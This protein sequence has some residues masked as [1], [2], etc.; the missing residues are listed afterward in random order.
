MLRPL[1]NRVDAACR[2]ALAEIGFKPRYNISVMD[3]GRDVV[4]SVGLNRA[5]HRASGVVAINPVMAVA[6]V[7][8]ELELARLEGRPP[9]N[10]SR[11]RATIARPLGYLMPQGSFTNWN[12]SEATDPDEIAHDIAA[13]VARYG[14]PFIEQ[15][16]SL[17]N[18]YD[19]MLTRRFGGSFP[20]FASRLAVAAN[21][22]GDTEAAWAFISDH[23]AMLE[24]RTDLDA[25]TFRKFAGRLQGEMRFASA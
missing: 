1:I 11:V 9:V 10:R 22:L 18:F 23:L 14:M 19:S 16:R 3:V 13:N 8:L 20:R 12:F 21:M 24:D 5:V 17:E 2:Q 4:A 6:H 7:P 15:H 25:E